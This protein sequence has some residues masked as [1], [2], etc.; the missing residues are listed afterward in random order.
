MV[1]VLVSLLVVS[2]VSASWFGD[3][4]GKISGKTISSDAQLKYRTSSDGGLTWTAPANSD[5]I[6]ELI[7]DAIYYNSRD[8]KLY[9]F[10]SSG[11]YKFKF[12]NNVWSGERSASEIFGNNFKPTAIQYD[13][14]DNKAYAFSAGGYYTQ[15]QTDLS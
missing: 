13:H 12:P 2:L 10:D 6:A 5:G 1:I 7:P 11:K 3:F 9:V 14:N 4:L 15:E 8:R